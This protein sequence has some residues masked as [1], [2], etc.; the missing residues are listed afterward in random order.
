MLK[1]LVLNGVANMVM[2]MD[3][4]VLFHQLEGFIRKKGGDPL[5]VYRELYTALEARIRDLE[6]GENTIDLDEVPR[7]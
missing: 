1:D 5:V 6:L 7:G 3:A 2:S 4:R